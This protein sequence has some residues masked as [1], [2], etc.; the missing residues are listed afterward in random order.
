MYKGTHLLIDCH[1]VPSQLCLNDELLLDVLARSAKKAGATVISQIRYRFGADSPPGCTAVVM[2]DESHC[3]VHSYAD[4][5]MMAFD[6]FTCGS[7]DPRFVWSLISD[8]LGIIDA[9][10]REVGRFIG[11][12]QPAS[13]SAT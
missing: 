10:I 11:S 13:A 4:A 12:G 2:L 3:S 8:E 1:N 9:D 6:I 7:T 5:G